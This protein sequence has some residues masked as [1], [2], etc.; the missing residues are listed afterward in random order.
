MNQRPACMANPN[1]FANMFLKLLC[2]PFPCAG[3]RIVDCVVFGQQGGCVPALH[4]DRCRCSA[5]T[6]AWEITLCAHLLPN[7]ADV[8][9]EHF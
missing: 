5:L 4:A 7:W 3:G 2:L 9:A 8:T 1:H 6:S